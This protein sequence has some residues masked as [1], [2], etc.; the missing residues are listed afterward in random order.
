MQK[1]T[2]LQFLTFKLDEQ[3]YALSIAN[4]VQVMRMVAVT[5]APKA[6]AFVEGVFNLRG[7]VVPVIDTRKR[8]GLLPKAWDLDTQLL[9]AQAHGLTIALIVDVVSEVLTLPV[10]NLE[11]PE[12]IGAAMAYLTAVGKLGDRLL[13][14][15]DPNKLL[16]DEIARLGSSTNTGMAV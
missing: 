6:P 2:E 1:E 7:K 16:T 13:L 9:I 8:L 11:P 12:Q 3:E 10:G 5:R 4:V 14:I 15:V